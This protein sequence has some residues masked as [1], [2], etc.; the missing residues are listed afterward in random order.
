MIARGNQPV[1]AVECKTG[2]R[3]LSRNIPYFAARS[4]IPVFYQVHAGA[5]DIEFAASRARIL[6]LTTLARILKV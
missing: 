2:E 3:D 5:K 1:F 4:N 6:P